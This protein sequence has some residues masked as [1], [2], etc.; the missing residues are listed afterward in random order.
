MDRAKKKNCKT[1]L[2]KGAAAEVPAADPL[3]LQEWVEYLAGDIGIRPQLRPDI[4]DRVAD[5]LS[6]QFQDL[7]YDVVLQPVPYGTLA[8][9]NVIACRRGAG[10][11][12]RSNRLLVVGAHYDTVSRSPGAD[13]NGSGVA[14]LMELARLFAADP[15]ACLRLVAFCPEEPPVYRTRQMGSYVYAA[16]LKKEKIELTGMI[17]LEMIG[18]FTDAAGSQSYPFPLMN[19]IYPACGNFIA[20]VGNLRSIDWTRRVKNAFCRGTDLPAERVNAPAIMVGIDFSDHWSFHRHGYQALMVT[21]TAFYRNP[22]YH[23]FSDLPGTID[24][25]RAAKVVD[26]VAAAIRALA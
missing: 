25:G 12:N 7:G 10:A 19:R 21:D 20:L 23:R 15:P 8:A 2:A 26:G 6:E 22:N 9:V 18:Y 11:G 13:D 14:G 4:L 5:R 1:V 17:C 16:S 3:R 24:Y